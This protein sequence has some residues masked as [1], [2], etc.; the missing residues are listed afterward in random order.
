MSNYK[1][2]TL[3]A[4]EMFFSIFIIGSMFLPWMKMDMSFMG[5]SQTIT[6]SMVDDTPPPIFYII[7]TLCIVNVIV[8]IFNRSLWLS[9]ITAAFPLGYVID[10]ANNL[11]EIR[12]RM[13]SEALN[14]GHVS[15]G[16]GAIL[17][18]TLSAAILISVFCEWIFYMQEKA[19]KSPRE[20]YK[21]YFLLMGIGIIISVLTLLSMGFLPQL[22]AG[23][24]ISAA[25]RGITSIMLVVIGALG[26][27]MFIQYLL[28]ALMTLAHHRKGNNTTQSE[29]VP[30]S[31]SEEEITDNQEDATVTQEAIPE[32]IQDSNTP[33]KSNRTI[34]YAIGGIIAATIIGI[35]CFFAF[36]K[37]K[38][39][40]SILGLQQP[41]WEKFVHMRGKETAFFKSPDTS[42]QRLMQASNDEGC[43]IFYQYLWSGEK[44]REGM[45]DLENYKYSDKTSVF[46]VIEEYE[47]WYKVHINDGE[48]LCEAYVEKT[49]CEE[50]K[51]ESI[52]QEILTQI[53]TDYH[54]QKE[55]KYANICFRLG[56]TESGGHL[57]MGELIDE[58]CL[59]FS[60]AYEMNIIES[61]T[62][63]NTTFDRGSFTFDDGTKEYF[64]TLYYNPSRAITLNDYKTFDTKKI[65]EAEIGKF[66]ST[67][68]EVKPKDMKISYE[69]YFPAVSTSNLFCFN[70]HN[71]VQET[72]TTESSDE[73]H[74]TEYKADDQNLMAL[75]DGEWIETGITSMLRFE[76]YQQQ[77]LDDDG[78]TEIILKN[79][80][81]GN[82]VYYPFVIY[83]DKATN[84]FK[85][86]KPMESEEEPTIETGESGATLIVQNEG[87]R[88]IK[89]KFAEGTLKLVSDKMKDVGKI[90]RT[91]SIEDVYP[92]D[93]NGE[94]NMTFDF[95]GDGEEENV[96]FYRGTT[97]AEGYGKYM[98]IKMIK[99]TDGRVA[100]SEDGSLIFAGTFR[101]L[102]PET[103]GMP[104]IIADSYLKKW[105]GSS[106][107]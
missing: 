25:T 29:V 104:D 8:K 78:N 101:F 28:L 103:N 47:N 79:F 32:N 76:V 70:I 83:Y 51:P 50:V 95:D 99:W 20:K 59:A 30:A 24:E 66:I 94:R 27:L 71:E 89:Y 62:T 26:I 49:Q 46:P 1:I 37:S 42:S 18:G 12:S 9:F 60:L 85:E 65:T 74:V 82:D 87:L 17:S 100:G 41:K 61:D 67:M 105:N 106:Y 54:L 57:C 5:T 84:S 75:I 96:T 22:I 31:S 86:S 102:A 72:T 11:H 23:E 7:C 93:G 80:D 35:I 14:F 19:S 43:E 6:K 90:R 33:K 15:L 107:E 45:T 2:T 58:K 68:K 56:N 97:H 64:F 10:M 16:A 88:T 69:Y 52:T 3:S 53:S 39:R 34:L 91:L 36:G 44:P 55:G 73:K 4:F 92:D 63:Q 21:R 98:E 77:D 48:K 81:G 13:A 40:E 38:Q